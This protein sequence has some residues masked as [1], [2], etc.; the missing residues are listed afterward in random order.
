MN[1]KSDIGGRRIGAGDL[2]LGATFG[3]KAEIMVVEDLLA[4]LLAPHR[5]CLAKVEHGSFDGADFARRYLL[6]VGGQVEVSSDADLMPQCGICPIEIKIGMLA[7]IG[8]GRLVGHRFI[9]HRKHTAVED[10][11]GGRDRAI[12]G[13]TG[14][15]IGIDYLQ[16]RMAFA[17]FHQHPVAFAHAVAAAMQMGYA[18]FV[19]FQLVFVP[20]DREPAVT[21]TVGVAA[22]GGAEIGGIFVILELVEAEHERR[23]VAL[24]TQ[25]LNDGTPGDDLGRQPAF[26]DGDA[27][28]FFAGRR[29]TEIL[30]CR[31]V[32]HNIILPV[33]MNCRRT[34][35]HF[36]AIRNPAIQSMSPKSVL[37]FWDK[38]MLKTKKK[39]RRMR[40][41]KRDAL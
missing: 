39:A 30:P 19:Q 25:I 33:A 22:G 8:D 41:T 20:V 18:L 37:R 31:R 14:A 36:P 7:D 11:I 23:L 5:C 35:R 40:L 26:R 1:L 29:E 13:I 2:A 9:D 17:M 28:D 12:A 3:R 21:D 27:F 4:I 16:N 38:D 34:L 15:A 32:A 10:R 24:K 6:V